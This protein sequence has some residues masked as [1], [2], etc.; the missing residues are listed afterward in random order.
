MN[1][2]IHLGSLRFNHGFSAQSP[3]ASMVKLELAAAYRHAQVKR[4]GI[5]NPLF[6]AKVPAVSRTQFLQYDWGDRHALGSNRPKYCCRRA[7]LDTWDPA[8]S[9][10]RAQ[11]QAKSIED[12]RRCIWPPG[13]RQNPDRTRI[14]NGSEF[15]FPR[16]GRF[17]GRTVRPKLCRFIGRS[18][19]AQ[20]VKR[21]LVPR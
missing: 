5:A 18:K 8:Q 15:R 10:D 7:K 16:Q 11:E 21:S 2:S 3:V 9:N 12:R 6:H 14:G 4:N 1:I 13:K 19:S 17:S 20:Q